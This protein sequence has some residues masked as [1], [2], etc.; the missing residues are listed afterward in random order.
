MEADLRYP[1]G[2][3]HRP[4]AALTADQRRDFIDE[5]NKRPRAWPPP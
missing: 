3:F 5:S 2:K 1:I 4:E